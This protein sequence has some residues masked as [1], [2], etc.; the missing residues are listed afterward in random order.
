MSLVNNVSLSCW[1]IDGAYYK[2]ADICKLDDIN[3]VDKLTQHDIICLVETHCDATQKPSLDGYAEPVSNVRPKTPGAPYNSGGIL[4]YIKSHIRR[5]IKVLP[6]T[7]SEYRWIK[8]KRSFFNMPY[9]IYIVVAYISNG[10]FSH[11]SDDVLALIENDSAKFSSDGSQLFA[12]GD[13]NARTNHDKDFCI[14]DDSDKLNDLID[15]PIHLNDDV[16]IARNNADSHK[17]DKRGTKLLQ[18]C[19][20]TGLRILNGRFFGDTV[21]N[22]TCFSHSGDPS[23]IDYMLA[24]VPLLD[25]VQYFHVNDLNVHSI[26]CPLSVSLSTGCHIP[27]TDTS[28]NNNNTN[29]LIPIKKFVWSPGNYAMFQNALES[30]LIQEKLENIFQNNPHSSSRNDVNCRDEEFNHIDDM[31]SNLTEIISEAAK[32]A[33]VR[34]KRTKK[35][36]SCKKTKSMKSKSKPWFGDNCKTL[37]MHCSKLFKLV[38]QNPFNRQLRFDMNRIRKLYKTTLKRNKSD[39]ERKIWSSLNECQNKNPKQ[40]WKLF[41]ELKGLDEKYKNN[42]IPMKDWVEHFTALLNKSLKPNPELDNEISAYIKLNRNSIFNELN[43]RINSEEIHNA[44]KSL[45]LNKAAGVDGIINEMFKAGIS[46]LINPLMKLFN[47]ILS[48]GHFPKNW[49]ENSLTPLLK[50]GDTLNPKNYRGIA[51]AE[52]I[53]KLFLT[54]LQRRLKNFV[55]KNNLVPNCQIAYKENSSTCDHILTLK[56]IIDK[57]INKVCRANLYICFVD[58]RSAFDTVWRKAMLYKLIK[59]GVGGNFINVIDSMYKNVFYRVKHNGYLSQKIPSNVGVKQGCV[60]SPLLFNLF[61]SDLPDVFTDNCCPV[62]LCDTK[63]NCLMFADD[64]VIISESAVGLQNCLSKLQLYCDKWSLSINTDK[65]KVMIFNKGGHRISRHRFTLNDSLIEIVQRYCYL[66]IVFSSTGKFNNACNALYEKALKAFYMF[67]QVHPHNNVKVAI[68]L[69]DTLV[70]PIVTYAS[71]VWAP[72]YAHKTNMDNFMQTCNDSPV[73]KLNVKLCKYL[74]GVHKS[75]TNNAVRGE[76]GRFP[77]LINALNHSVRYFNRID[78]LA[79]NSLVKLSCMDDVVRSLDTSWIST[80]N[81]IIDTFSGPDSYLANMQKVYSDSWSTLIQSYDTDG[82]LRVYSQFKKHFHLENYLVQ[83]PLYVRRNLTKLRISAHSLAI[84]TG[85]YTRPNKTDI[86]KRLCFHCKSIESEFHVVFDCNLYNDER[87]TFM[88][89]VSNFSNI[90]LVLSND[91]FC[92][93]MSCHQGD[94]DFGKAFCDFV[95]SC[96]EKRSKVLKGIR[97]KNI[98]CRPEETLTRYGRLSKRPTKLDL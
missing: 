19:K 57:Y 6:E 69:F 47:A 24:T 78:S 90:S 22:F 94:V 41:S 34:V 16:A 23:T 50:K 36:N 13:F 77:L 52:S 9:D 66:G 64:L 95:N 31:S 32:I 43:F 15:L 42:P 30:T 74:L 68:H 88:E 87:V 80:M 11:K 10:S 39:F 83:F 85:R 97:E 5:G 58:F 76:L 26:H 89:C 33:G 73:E 8:L 86:D 17:T 81:K 82:K 56:N 63:L 25:K 18:L 27:D 46:S 48:N 59:L 67:K 1:N 45:K 3:V 75:S 84:E 70:Q 93:L 7:N 54:V 91:T 96:F 92:I 4:I 51:V 72:L 71:V 55:Y 21:G 40:F 37:K 44:V 14:Q 98:Y 60:L 61:L 35:H 62:T 12:C 49:Q 79:I 28:N 53:S 29:K 65:T 38:K 20:S 2:G